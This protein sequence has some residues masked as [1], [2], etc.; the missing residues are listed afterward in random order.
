VNIF[1][2]LVNYVKCQV[3][4]INRL[5]ARLGYF[6]LLTLSLFVSSQAFT[7]QVTFSVDM[8]GVNLNGNSV[9]VVGGFPGC[10]WDVT[11]PIS[12]MTKN[13]GNEIWTTQI[14]LSSGSYSYKFVIGNWDVQEYPPSNCASTGEYINREV[15]LFN[16]DLVL[17]IT[18]FD[19]CP[20]MDG[21]TNLP[22]DPNKQA[23]DSTRWF[24]Q[25]QLP[26]GWG[27]YNDEQQ[28]YTNKIENSYTSDGTLK[29]VARKENFTDQGHT[30]PYTS[31]R[32]NSKFAFKY[33]KVEFR[34]KMPSG[35][36]TWPAVWMLNK[37]INE[38]GAYFYDDF[39]TTSWPAAG[40]IDILEHW[41]KDPYY[42]QSAM[43]TTSSS[44]GTINHGG[45]VI[46]T[47]FS[48]FHTYTMDWNQDRI[49]FAI[50]GTEHYTYNP[51]VKNANTWPYDDEFYLLLN[52]AIE[53]EEITDSNLNFALMEVDYIRVYHHQTNQ[54]IWSDE[55]GIVDNSD[56]N[57]DD[58][59][60]PLTAPDP[61]ANP[62]DVLSI[63]GTT[64]GNLAG[65]NFDP[66][67]GQTTNAVSGDEYVL[68]NLNYQGIAFDSGAID[69][70]SYDY[71]HLDY[72]TDN[73]TA[74]NFY[75][76]SPGPNETVF[77]LDL[78]TKGQWNSVDIP[79]AAFTGVDL[80][81]V[82]QMKF[83]GNGTL[84]IDN[85]YFG[86]DDSVVNP[87][88]LTAP[89]PTANPDDVLSIFGTTYGNLSGT[90]FDPD[91]GQATHAV[92]G[93]EYVLNNLNY[94]GIA[95][96]SG[97]LDVSSYD[98]IHL[99]YYTDNSTAANFYL[100]SP[101]PIEPAFALDLSIKSQ[102]NSVDIPLAVFAEADL[103]DVFQMK[104]DGNGTL[105]IDN[106][107][108]A[109]VPVT[110]SDGDGVSDD[111]D[112]F[113]NNA[114]EDTDTDSDGVGN[115]AD[116]FPNDPSETAD[117]DNDGVG[118]NSDAFPNDASETSDTDSDGVGD[119]SDAFPNNPSETA[120]SDN[121]GVGDN[122]DAFSND[123]SETS[124]TDRDGVGDNSDAF[125]NDP[126]ESADSD[127]DGVGD[128]SDAFPNDPSETADTDN[129]GIG[130]NADTDDDGD[131]ISDV[132]DT[133]P[134][135]PNNYDNYQVISV[136]STP[137]AARGRTITLDISYDVSSNENQLTGLGL[138]LHYD[139]TKLEF[140][141]VNNVLTTDNII[142][143]DSS[144]PDDEN[145]DLNTATDRFVPLAWASL[146]GNWPNVELPTALFS[147]TFNVGIDV[148]VDNIEITTIGFSKS[149]NAT[150]YGFSAADFDLQI[151]PATW[152]FDSNGNA[153][154]LTDGLLLLRHAFGL[155]GE[156]LTGGA[157]ASDSTMSSAEVEQALSSAMMIA[158][159]DDNGSV[160]ALTDG[161]LLLRYL[162][163][164]RDEVL[165][166]GAVSTSALRSS[167]SDISDYIMNHMPDAVTAED[168]TA[169][170]IT[171]NS[172]AI[173]PL[174][175]DVNYIEPG[176]IA[177]DDRDGVI[178]V[179][180]SGVVGSA[181]GSY[182]V[183]YTATDAAGNSS[184]VTRT[185]IV[186]VAP[187][188]SSIELLSN[189]NPSLNDD[190]IL[191][192]DG[193][194]FSGRV[195]QNIPVSDLYASFTHDGATVSVADVE[196][197]SGS[198]AN[199]F[200]ELVEYKVSKAN[201]VSKTYTIDLTK[202]TGL[203]IVNIQTDGNLPIE[204]K[205][206][207][208]T[209]TVTIDGGR[210]FNDLDSTIME[211]RGRGNST[212]VNPK[213]P[214][215]MKLDSKEK[216]LDMP[217]QKKWIFLAEYSDK[218]LL[219]N[220]IAFELGYLSTLDWTPK[221]EFAEVYI[222]GEYNGTYNI[223]E[224]VEEKSARVDIGDA[225]FL[226]EK[227][228]NVQDRVDP[229]DVYFNTSAYQNENIIVIKEP[230]IDRIDANDFAFE[231][232]SRFIYIRDHINA[233]ETALFGNDFA[234]PVNGY[235]SFIDVDSFIDWFLIN[236]ISKNVD[237]RQ[238]SSIYFT[239]IPGEKIKMGPLWDFDL[240]FGNM[241]YGDP[242]FTE[243]WHVRYHAWISRLLDDPLF[244]TQVQ[245]RFIDHYLANKQYIL[246]KIDEQAELLKW[247]QHE[248]FNK[249][250][251]LGVPVWPNPYVWDTYEEEVLYLKTW[252][253]DRMDWLE[254]ALNALYDQPEEPI[255]ESENV[256]VTFQVDMNYIETNAEGVYLAG[257]DLGQA[258]YLMTDNGN[259]V[260]SVTLE[261]VPNFRYY[262]KF[263]N[264]PS[265]GTWNGFES[266]EGLSAGECGAG[267]WSDR[268][269]D[270]GNNDITLDI[271]AYGSCTSQPY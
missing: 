122:S 8:S 191:E 94:Q 228:T 209:G 211:I 235:A 204:S 243:G 258:G 254:G 129:D 75:L 135:I 10:P 212:W 260:W 38:P 141:G 153:D 21:I 157:I 58:T 237:S 221:S 4:A 5:K 77:A 26:N 100:I 219:R 63:F 37:N 111:A 226:L 51:A 189:N 53:K 73:S 147:I 31:A 177:T 231:Q 187:T 172:D 62:D 55:F 220:T 41:G 179:T 207:Y 247:A 128:N 223:S 123:A 155:N 101:G 166:S 136:S 132:D 225:G 59:P 125:P 269:I 146:F 76:I 216:F 197:T 9:T 3:I 252:Y 168:I 169:P 229:D 131:G 84:R 91:W 156:V 152:D 185:V 233:F 133:E 80:T 246:D 208:I 263:R 28:H 178:E 176:A 27:W 121:D 159:I 110:D 24:H 88:P 49:V 105:R 102:W 96:D 6:S 85:I 180:V 217:K 200:T 250:Q 2:T 61:T 117:S 116:A 171:L 104:F 253:E 36:G 193:T 218:S 182:D 90:N 265:Y 245:D 16:N 249:W 151:M 199:D 43:H 215:Q 65:T 266:G 79:L 14:D 42:A 257:G 161:L 124:D 20:G 244:V 255:S 118:D 150:G 142:N 81:E 239:H 86:E 22:A 113:P 214:Y 198:T 69:V 202:F 126:S 184:S 64:Y 139:S 138:R 236:E 213:K 17:P 83:D 206:D 144:Q 271:V 114:S 98:Y 241:N 240:G 205:D 140:A 203:P 127:N 183:T 23:I 188:M 234:D 18:P 68:N 222:N 195:S 154:A 71:I 134:L 192:M 143:G 15:T 39:A 196:Q 130:N 1:N 148:A 268:F 145:F 89:D 181:I 173:Y 119:N 248:N 34:A 57:S 35:V 67:W 45:Q 48:E 262:F 46:P 52:I 160:D 190:I 44:G 50:D 56:D 137:N 74:A 227:D 149:S 175:F 40:E 163:G 194:T 107:Y 112:A 95:F 158:D 270:V 97:A 242:Q 54:L 230:G 25:T 201:G 103:T 186:D 93:D 256:F 238:F 66:D 109:K 224:K 261:L 165:I 60:D 167:H 267:E 170:Q 99:D 106:I 87:E 174:A 210:G 232:D 70:S 164:L 120:D 12:Q 162:F 251:I 11:C 72:Y 82:F 47:I 92:S 30:K 29:I 33:G 13:T 78:S 7:A 108:F 32:L 259:D 19:G 264:Q 115:N